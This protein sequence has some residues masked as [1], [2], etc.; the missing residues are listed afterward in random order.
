MKLEKNKRELC[1][2]PACVW[3]RGGVILYLSIFGN[4][5][6]NSKPEGWGFLNLAL[7]SFDGSPYI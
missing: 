4:K 5:L 7:F 6:T 3:E 1:F 2:F